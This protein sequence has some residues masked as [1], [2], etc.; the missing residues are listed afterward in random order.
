M[1][2]HVDA[3][4]D[5]HQI[6]VHTVETDAVALAVMV[7]ATLTADKEVWLPFRAGKHFRSLAAHQMEA[8]LRLEKTCG[9]L[10]FHTLTGCDTMS[11]FVGC[12]NKTAWAAW[13]SFP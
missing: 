1:M 12:G 8:C 9:L 4:H 13:N 6:L 7:A 10:T 2:L 5:C 11:A 3:Q